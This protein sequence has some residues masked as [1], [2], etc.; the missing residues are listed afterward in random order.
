MDKVDVV[1]GMIASY[2]GT[3][4]MLGF[5]FL[6]D[7]FFGLRMSE[8]SFVMS[9]VIC[10]TSAFGGVASGFGLAALLRRF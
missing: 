5:L 4:S 8:V 6:W 9:S 1:E 2:L 7:F 10:L 3:F